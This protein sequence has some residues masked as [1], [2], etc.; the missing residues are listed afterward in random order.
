M[1]ITRRAFAGTIATL[2]APAAL[3][4]RREQTA[5]EAMQ[6]VAEISVV[7]DFVR[8]HGLEAEFGAPGRFG[9]WVPVNH[10]L[11]SLPAIVFRRLER[12]RDYAREV[13]LNHI[14]TTAP[15]IGW[16]G[17]FPEPEMVAL[18]SRAGNRLFIRLGNFLPR[19][20]GQPILRANIRVANGLGYAIDGVLRI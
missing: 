2:A 11:E 5:W 20:N 4:Q 13:I 16:G 3:A 12:D 9:F 7:V 10:G 1:P 17:N 18:E 14:S 19:I 15:V 6:G 8:L